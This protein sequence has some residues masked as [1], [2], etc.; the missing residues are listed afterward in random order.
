R[1]CLANLVRIEAEIRI[2]EAIDLADQPYRRRPRAAIAELGTDVTQPRRRDR[3]RDRRLQ[4]LALRAVLEVAAE[5]RVRDHPVAIDQLP[6]AGARRRSLDVLATCRAAR[7]IELVRRGAEWAR[8]SHAQTRGRGDRDRLRQLDSRAR[9]VDRS[10][11]PAV[12]GE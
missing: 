5:P 4:H 9:T 3:C 7:A 11:A 6:R 12:V 1:R 8:R 10:R 2:L